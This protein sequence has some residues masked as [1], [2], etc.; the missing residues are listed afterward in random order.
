MY[1]KVINNNQIIDVLKEPR[2]VKCLPRSQKV[3]SIEQAQANGVI[4]S[5]GDDIYHLHG[6]LNTYQE[7]KRE[8]ILEEINEEE[9]LKLT[10]QV[11]EN[12]NLEI[13]I[14][15]LENLVQNLQILISKN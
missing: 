7:S 14:K 12:K 6:T 13:R 4:S 15:E 3:I 5:N 10:T 11:Q 1:Y 9:Y 2:F 8:V